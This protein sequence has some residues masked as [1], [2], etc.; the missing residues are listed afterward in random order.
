MPEEMK[1]D[2]GKSNVATDELKTKEKS[3]DYAEAGFGEVSLD[4]IPDG[5][6]RAWG[7][8]LGVSALF[9]L[10]SL[11]SEFTESII[12]DGYSNSSPLGV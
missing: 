5:G 9:F 11:S 4:T 10:F 3:A 8:V 12:L 7:V 2:N 1:V 6:W